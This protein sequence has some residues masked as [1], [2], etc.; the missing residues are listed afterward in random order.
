MTER[1]ES[2]DTRIWSGDCKRDDYTNASDKYL[3][4]SCGVVPNLDHQVDHEIF[5]HIKGDH[6]MLH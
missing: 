4:V 1:T 6:S 5:P 3:C 2:C